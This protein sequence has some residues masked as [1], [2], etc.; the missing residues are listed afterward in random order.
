MKTPTF[1]EK[2]FARINHTT[3]TVY[4]PDADG[5]ET[6]P[7]LVVIGGTCHLPK[8]TLTE[9]FSEFEDYADD[10]GTTL[11]DV[12]MLNLKTKTWSKAF[13]ATT[14]KSVNRVTSSLTSILTHVSRR[15]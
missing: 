13:P 6:T 5:G 7:H 3:S 14:I 12:H 1:G 8:L 9:D 11:N 15:S 4:I 10:C 2:P